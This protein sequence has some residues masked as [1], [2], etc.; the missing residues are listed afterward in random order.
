[1]ANRSDTPLNVTIRQIQAF[2][3]VAELGSFTR[4]AERLHAAQPALSLLLRQLEE[5]L[6]A[7]LLDR[8]TRRVELTEAGR[9]VTNSADR[10]LDELH[11]AARSARDH[12]ARRRGRISIVA[13]PLLAAVL[14]PD[15]IAE[16]G[17]AHPGIEIKLIEARTDQIVD[18]VR[19]GGADCGVG[20]F[21]IDESGIDRTRLT[22][23]NLML[24][25]VPGCELA[26]RPKVT[27]DDVAR[28]GLPL[29]T[30]TRDSGI[31][32]LVEVGFESARKPLLPAFEVTQ[33]TT[34]L[35]LTAANLGVAVLPAYAWHAARHDQLVAR[36]MAKPSIVRDI[37]MI[38]AQGRSRTP[39]VIAFE[40]VLRRHAQQHVPGEIAARGGVT[41]SRPRG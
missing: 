9:E 32:L 5:E 6:G 16:F 35:A 15:A 34:A 38:S 28:S 24:F 33:I 10:I 11:H 39:A 26:G 19:S 41:A 36:E 12:A 25:C 37:V 1:M 22:R 23:D 13:P 14:L 8:T 18:L 27:W 30:L 2:L 21:A 31:R 4:A 17:R 40:A 7:R 3:A 29:I 20:T